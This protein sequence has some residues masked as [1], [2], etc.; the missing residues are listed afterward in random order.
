MPRLVR[1]NPRRSWFVVLCLGVFAMLGFEET[2]ALLDLLPV[3]ALIVI[4]LGAIVLCYKRLDDHEVKD[5]E[6][7]NRVN[8]NTNLLIYCGEEV[9]YHRRCD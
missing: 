8:N 4:L 2:S 1:N 6:V 3:Q 5:V 7:Q 9:G